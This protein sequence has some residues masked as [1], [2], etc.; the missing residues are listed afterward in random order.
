MAQSSAVLMLTSVVFAV[1]MSGVMSVMGA[2]TVPAGRSSLMPAVLLLAMFVACPPAAPV[3]GG[4]GALGAVGGAWALP[5][6]VSGAPSSSVSGVLPPA[7]SGAVAGVGLRARLAVSYG[8]RR[9]P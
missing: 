4:G 6:A 3:A 5:P 7:M 2:G 9:T 1:V 8:R